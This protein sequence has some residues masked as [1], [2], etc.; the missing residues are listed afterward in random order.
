MKNVIL[1]LSMAFTLWQ[2]ALGAVVLKVQSGGVIARA[3]IDLD[4][5][6]LS[7]K[8]NLS[9]TVEGPAPI[10]VGPILGAALLTK[11]SAQS[12][13]V[14]ETGAPAVEDLKNGAR[15]WKQ[16]FRLAPF[17]VGPKVAI[18]LAPLKIKAGNAKETE[19]SWPQ[20]ATVEV[21][22]SIAQPDPDSL[23]PVT[24]IEPLP[25]VESANVSDRSWVYSIGIAIGVVIV[26]VVGS[27]WRSRRQR[28]RNEPL[29]TAEWAI[30]ELR[31][32]APGSAGFA[33]MAEVLRLCLQHRFDIPAPRLTTAEI[34]RD[35]RAHSQFTPTLADELK[36][37]LERCDIAKFAEAVVQTDVES[38]WH[39]CVETAVRFIEKSGG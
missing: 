18:A 27:L 35:F 33:R 3:E 26:F 28:E 15:R 25:S 14:K 38:D 13:E 8:L 34:V 17:E 7:G 21:T 6:K 9:L 1:A 24:D 36:I 37:I 19:V 16:E 23:R 39:D 31:G 11:N 2:P 32:L 4:R 12:W 5:V 22:T 29:Y 20:S 30:A 10:E